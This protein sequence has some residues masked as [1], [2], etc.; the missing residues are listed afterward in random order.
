MTRVLIVDDH[1]VV[2]HG[3]KDI[4]TH[5][6]PDL[7]CGEANDAD[8]ALRQLE[9]DTWNL[10]ILD[11]T[12]PGRSGFDLL[13]TLQQRLPD[14]PILVLSML[15]EDQYGKRVLQA[16]AR[17]FMNKESASE[18]LIRAVTRILAGG[19]YISEAL[20]ERLAGDLE[21][22]STRLPHERLSAREFEVLRSLAAGKTVSQIADE[23]QLSVPTISTYRARL[24]E[25]MELTTTADLIHY[26]VRHDLL[27]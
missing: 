21:R 17:G 9:R 18:E 20:A 4:L 26:A 1:T 14:L 15:P 19:R 11:L 7:V 27:P 23:L 12:L 13:R 2:R 8:A 25:K 3:L 5:E 6:W 10:V 24:L 22:N 16:G